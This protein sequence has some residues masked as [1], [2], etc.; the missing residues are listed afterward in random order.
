MLLKQTIIGIAVDSNGIF[1]P[2]RSVMYPKNILP[3]KPPIHIIEATHE[4][5]STVNGPLPNCGVSLDFSMA[6][7]ADDHPH[8]E[9]YDIA[10]KFPTIKRE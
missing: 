3:K 2:Q 9:P 8:V 7:A 1:R 10:I 4:N 6:P 5:S